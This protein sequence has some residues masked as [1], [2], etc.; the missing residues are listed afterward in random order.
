MTGPDPHLMRANEALTDLIARLIKWR[1]RSGRDRSP[2]QTQGWST[3][4]DKNTERMG[5][6][7]SHSQRSKGAVVSS[8]AALTI[9]WRGTPNSDDWVAYIVEAKSKKLILADHAA[10]G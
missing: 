9:A 4:S 5:P 2:S 10:R 6:G 8:S 1:L 7:G 3:S